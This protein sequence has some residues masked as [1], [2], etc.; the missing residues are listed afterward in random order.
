MSHSYERTAGVY[1]HLLG[2]RLIERCK[3]VQPLFPLVVHLSSNFKA[4]NTCLSALVHASSWLNWTLTETSPILSFTILMNISRVSEPDKPVSI[5]TSDSTDAENRRWGPELLRTRG[6]V[7]GSRGRQPSRDRIAGCEGF[8][9]DGGHLNRVVLG[10]LCHRLFSLSGK[11][12]PLGRG[13]S[14]GACVRVACV[15]LK[16]K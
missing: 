8:V 12:I 14:W 4:S 7:G 11:T 1:S 6:F 13:S 5:S 16:L 10:W 9:R 3:P 2:I 15:R